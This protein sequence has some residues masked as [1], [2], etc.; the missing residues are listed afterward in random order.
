MM[1]S[2]IKSMWVWLV[3]DDN[4]L[5]DGIGNYNSERCKL[6]KTGIDY[7]LVEMSQA[8][9]ETVCSEIHVVINCSWNKEP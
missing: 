1:L 7:V 4:G 2:G 3:P 5:E 9:G 8:A 6:G